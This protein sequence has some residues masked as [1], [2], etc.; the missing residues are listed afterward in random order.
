MSDTRPNIVWI[1]LEDTSATR[2]SCYGD[3]IAR[4]PN[5]D[6][7]AEESRLYEN[8]FSTSP[9]CSPSRSA[10]ITGMYQSAIGC[11]NHRAWLEREYDTGTAL[12]YQATPPYY[13]RAFTEYLRREGYYCTKSGKNDFNFATPHSEDNAPFTVW[14]ECDP[15]AGWWSRPDDDQPFFAS[16]QN[17]TTHES[18]MWDP[19]RE[20]PHCR[21]VSEPEFD[22]DAVEVPPYLPDCEATRTAI[23]RQYDQLE[24]I[25]EWV[26]GLLERLEA[27][28]LRENTIVV[29][30]SD[31]GQG[32]P[33][34]KSW[35]Y[36]GGVHV[37]L[38]VRW[39]GELDAEHR[40]ELV[41]N[42]DLARTML[43][44]TDATTPRHLQGNQVFGAGRDDPREY[45]FATRDRQDV[46]YLTQRMVRDSQYKYIR[47]WTP[48]PAPWFPYRDNHPVS[49]VLKRREREGTLDDSLAWIEEP[50][51]AEELYELDADP[52]ETENLIDDPAY[53]DPRERLREA[54]EDWQ[55]RTTDLGMRT[56]TELVE[57]WWPD[58][59]QP[60][61][62]MPTF[63]PNAA[64][65]PAKERTP[66]GGEFQAPATVQLHCSTQGASLAYAKGDADWT[67]YDGAIDLEVGETTLRAKAV[68]Y[69]YEPSE[70][71]VATFELHE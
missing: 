25:D 53:S 15:E 50:L 43:E 54:L 46:G 38:I 41:S 44:V 62:A 1:N 68:R 69:G 31:H 6:A 11:H 63:I 16:F 49:K 23:A 48:G 8:A 5:I 17:S 40:T 36:D 39:P 35:L 61:T 55:D 20:N 52:H 3:D 70:E 32:L 14:N 30:W 27:D 2:L 71:R 37:P 33:R 56:E 47:N 51:P 57:S 42:V 19:D 18:G 13:V 26:G 58:G 10:T 21:A 22:P 12:P 67:L 65:N 9:V 29:I 24:T 34:C 7:F 64:G 66:D 45:V 60:T 28:D 4:T 59:E